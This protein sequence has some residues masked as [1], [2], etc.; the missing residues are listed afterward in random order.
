MTL[1]NGQKIMC[2]VALAVA[3]LVLAS[4]RMSCSSNDA[5]SV[6]IHGNR[7]S[8]D[9]MQPGADA[10]PKPASKIK[11]GGKTPKSVPYRTIKDRF[12]K[13]D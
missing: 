12:L 8:R 3:L 4:I 10:A 11:R 5:G 6:T 1:T 2:G 7:S 9:V 13:I